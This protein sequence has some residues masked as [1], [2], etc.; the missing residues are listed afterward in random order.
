MRLRPVKG[1][2]ER[3]KSL[4]KKGPLLI[5][6]ALLVC[7]PVCIA[8]AV[9]TTSALG[10][11]TQ[12]QQQTAKPSWLQSQ[13]KNYLGSKLLASLPSN[14]DLLDLQSILNSYRNQ[15]TTLKA[16]KPLDPALD[17]QIAQEI[18]DTEAKIQIFSNRLTSLKA[19][20]TTLQLAKQSLTSALAR[21]ELANTAESAA[22]SILDVAITE[23]S[24]ATANSLNATASM[25][26][27]EVTLGQAK[28]QTA[29]AQQTATLAQQALAA[30]DAIMT[31]AQQALQQQQQATDE[32]QANLDASQQTVDE[33]T[34]AQQ[35]ASTTYNEAD[36]NLQTAQN[37]YDTLLISDPNWTAPTYQKEHI[38]TVLNTRQVEVRTLVP[39]T[40]TSF[41]EQVIPNLLPNP[42]LTTTEGWSGVYPGWQ[43]S[44]P[45][46]YD[47]EITF[48]YMDQTVSQGLYSGP[49]N[50]A[51][52]TLSADWF[53]DWTADSYSMTVTAE[54]INRNPVGTATYTNTRTAHD[55]TNRSV[56]LTAT[57]PVSY[58]T[59]SFSGIDHGFWYGMYGPRMKNPALEVSYG[60]LVTE[61][62]YEEVITYEEE[63]YY[64]YET[65]YTT[66]PL[67]TEGTI[68]VQINE[69]GQATYT[70]PEGAVFTTSNLRYE[71]KGRPECGIDIRPNLQGNQ[72]TISA[73]NAIWGDPCGGWYKHIIGTIS[74][75][76]QPTA[77]LIKN[78]DL[79]PPLQVAQ[80]TFDEA[81][82]ALLTA[83]S[84][85]Q[86]AQQDLT[87]KQSTL[88]EEST[89]LQNKRNSLNTETLK[90]QALQTSNEAANQDLTAKQSD[91]TTAQDLYDQSVTNLLSFTSNEASAKEKRDVAADNYAAS[92][93]ET[94]AATSNKTAAE[95]ELTEAE[96]A[97]TTSNEDAVVVSKISLTKIQELLNQE[98][99]KE[100]EGSEEIPATIENLM[101]VDLNAVD[102]TELTEEQAGQLIEAA[103]VAFE[104][105]VEGSP[106][107]EQ[108]LEALYLAAE[109]DDIE[110]PQELAAIPGLAG[111][112]EVLNFL[113][114]AGADMSPKVREESEKVVVATVVA[115]GA[116]IQSA[117]AAAATASAPSGG[118][119]RIGK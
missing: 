47:G 65:Y 42:T 87:N 97:A 2:G 29:T 54:D 1:E 55:W 53:S 38:R 84:Q 85:L 115:A 61:T 33:A 93:S 16:S 11:P 101:D 3:S 76:G 28:A 9:T 112:V 20:L 88:N 116:A 90:S 13:P 73:N 110:L 113:G 119:R 66:E 68:Q 106:E 69:G 78:P 34:A 12:Y 105:A 94:S 52:L 102:P 39:T 67:L 86:T 40:T 111:A 49:F 103:L 71:A 5:T 82:S 96:A 31:Q 50:N 43:G 35:E 60:Q 109:Q 118:S 22:K 26:L 99:P 59:V 98:P 24:L 81:E 92:Q 15:L 27:A 4:I 7:Y 104:T 46:M 37:N 63:T 56:T 36:Q 19:N 89:K 6:T 8:Q 95:Q 62:T 70:A 75:L 72:I 25:E 114:N 30:Q 58:I 45:G 10:L 107:Y 64:T 91:Q 80:E 108:A 57:G 41:Q 17:T 14:Q 79:L 18:A 100:E 21:L 83:N 51:T 23:H 117:A 44:Q 32:A 77:P 48:S 74:Y